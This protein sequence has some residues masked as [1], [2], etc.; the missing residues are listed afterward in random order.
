MT[1]VLAAG[2][3]DLLHYGHIR[4]LEEAKKTGGPDAKLVVIVAR[5]ETV[6]S[7]KGTDPVIP[8]AQ[9]RAVIDA[10]KVVDE[11]LLGFK[12]MDLDRVLQ[13]IKPDIVAVGHDQ[14]AIK[15]QVEK[16]NKAREMDIKIVQIEQFGEDELNSS[17][18]IK[19]R[20]VEGA[21]TRP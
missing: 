20:I 19:R 16:I 4:Y 6:R 18:E 11:A 14:K 8:E 17:S 12:D 13:Q 21:K 7:L 1:T 10:L 5:D 9:R 3:F 15:A 2:V